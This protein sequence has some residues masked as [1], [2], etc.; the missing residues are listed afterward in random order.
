MKDGKYCLLAIDD[1]PIILD[2]IKNVFNDLYC[3]YTTEDPETALSLIREGIV[4]LVICDQRM[5]KIKGVELLAQIKQLDEDVVRILHTGYAD[6][7]V[8]IDAV[9]IGSIHR[10]ESKPVNVKNLRQVIKNEL[11]KAQ[12]SK[13]A[14]EKAAQMENMETMLDEIES[15][16]VDPEEKS[17]G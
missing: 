13:D 15:I 4:D 3:V 8:A 16:F 1:E 12:H 6:L 7:N 17:K 9:N 10:Y 14:K 11:E 5:P 2:Q